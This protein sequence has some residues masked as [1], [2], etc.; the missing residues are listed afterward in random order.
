[1]FVKKL[2]YKA[3]ENDLAAF[4]EDCGEVKNVKILYEPDGRSKG[5]AFVEFGTEA[6]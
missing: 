5:I 3:T 4:F 6:E 1:V 2:A